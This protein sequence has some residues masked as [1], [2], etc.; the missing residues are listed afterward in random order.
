M[1][2]QEGEGHI[3]CVVGL[4]LLLARRLKEDKT[5]EGDRV[6]KDL[7][8][9]D[10]RRKEDGRGRDEEDVLEDTRE[11]EDES[12]RGRDEEDGGNVEREGN[13]SIGKE[14]KRADAEDVVKGSK[15]L[16]EGNE[17]RVDDGADGR[18]EVDRDER[19]HLHAVE[20]DFNHDKARRLELR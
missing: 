12:R 11:G 1:E 6:T 7:E 16:G 3:V 15:A 9:G 20:E 8:R 19:V 18:E 2:K 14:R 10:G 13:G 5:A 17:A 4:R